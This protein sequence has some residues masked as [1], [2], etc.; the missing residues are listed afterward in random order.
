MDFSPLK[1]LVPFLASGMKQLG[2]FIRLRIDPCQVSALV[3]IA[4]NAGESKVIEVI[5]SAV[6]LWNDVLDVERRQR[7]I[8]LMLTAILASVLCPL[9]N[10]GSSL[11]PDHLGLRV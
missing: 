6:N 11:R 9:T 7:G 4:I 1:M 10:L 5:G 2:N 8:I 3:Q